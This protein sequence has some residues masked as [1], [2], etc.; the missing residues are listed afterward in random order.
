MNSI[1]NILMVIYVSSFVPILFTAFILWKDV[2]D[3][4]QFGKRPVYFGIS[5]LL[6]LGIGLVT[7]LTILVPGIFPPESSFMLYTIFAI[8]YLLAY[9]FADYSIHSQRISKSFFQ[10]EFTPKLKS[11]LVFLIILSGVSLLAIILFFLRNSF[12]GAITQGS[13]FHGADNLETLRQTGELFKEDFRIVSLFLSL[14]FFGVQLVF[15]I[16]FNRR[17]F[18]F[19]EG[20]IRKSAILA[21]TAILTTVF[22]V[23]Y[24][25]IFG[26]S[27]YVYLWF[28]IISNIVYGVRII[29][30]YFFQR[31]QNLDRRIE[32]QAETLQ[33]KNE[34]IGSV[35]N[36]TTEED[37]NIIR[38]S[39]V[40][41]IT[42]AKAL[43]TIHEYG[44]SGALVYSRSG[45]LLKV[46][47]EEHIYGYCLPLI[48]LDMLKHLKRK[49]QLH[50]N[51]LKATFNIDIIQNTNPENLSMYG[52]KLIKTILDTK[53]PVIID[54]IPEEIKGLQRMIG[55]FPIF[56]NDYLRGILVIFKDS[57]DRFFPEEENALQVL[58][59]N[60]KVIYSIIEGKYIQMERNRLQ[61]EIEI[62]KQIQTS[63]VPKTIDIP[64]YECAASMTT[65]T[66]VGGDVY[67][68][69]SSEFGTYFGIG[70][71]SG[72]GLPA[73]ITALIQLSAFQAAVMASRTLKKR[74]EPFEIYDLVNKVLCEINRNRIGSDKFMTQN[75][76]LE[77]EGKIYHAGSHVISLLYQKHD[78]TVRELDELSN[79]TAFLGISEHIASESSAGYFEMKSGDV[80]LLY[81]DGIIEAKDHYS[82]QFGVKNLIQILVEHAS[83][84]LNSIMESIMEA[85]QL[86]SKTGDIKKYNGHLADDASLF[87]I[88]KK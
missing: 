54:K 20:V 78:E 53:K 57:F 39:I 13:G 88:R 56:D 74:L 76:F 11:F 44:I 12:E 68:Y 55:L 83:D 27:N 8:I 41:A 64:G 6:M 21:N 47:S 58:I 87:V 35:I 67:D 25:I 85:V 50:E 22:Y 33:L 18:Q 66:E 51:I 60:L 80:L 26:F 81:T 19:Q 24:F 15:V 14:I 86:H 32:K 71:V 62:A 52:E 65:A 7:L 31:T 30:E 48:R 34:L 69:S 82:H 75:Y 73:G 28:F 42:R 49:E 79:R 40:D 9:F 1:M 37:I 38:D 5:M 17:L 29:N 59:E 63:I 45:K 43:L 72:H 10:D 16:G 4:P 77:R 84:D 23:F 46:F 61:G 70:D 3:R 36:S 2:T